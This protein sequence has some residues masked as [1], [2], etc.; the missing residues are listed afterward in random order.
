MDRLI[1]VRARYTSAA[2]SM[3][4]LGSPAKR[5]AVIPGHLNGGTEIHPSAC[6]AVR[7]SA[8][9][10]SSKQ[11]YRRPYPGEGMRAA[12]NLVFMVVV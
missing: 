3:E 11:K 4:E 1:N 6:V 7:S 9:I 5:L 8:P 10:S 2:A 12:V